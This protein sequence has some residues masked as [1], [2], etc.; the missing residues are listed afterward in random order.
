MNSSD[1]YHFYKK[2]VDDANKTMPAYKNVKRINIRETEFD[3]TTTGKIKR[4]GANTEHNTGKEETMNYQEI[5]NMEMKRAK[6]FAKS[7]GR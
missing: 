3:K 1:V 4:Y 7:T 6:A 2:I 5:K